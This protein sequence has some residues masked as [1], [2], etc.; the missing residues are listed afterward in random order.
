MAWTTPQTWIAGT[1]PGASD[2][3]TQIRDNLNFLL[4]GQV[5][6]FAQYTSSAGTTSTSFVDVDATNL[7][8]SGLITTGRALVIFTLVGS[9]SFVSGAGSGFYDIIRNSTTR[10]G[11][12]TTGLMAIPNNTPQRGIPVIA[13]FTGLSVGLHD[14]KLQFRIENSLGNSVAIS[15][16]APVTM[17]LLEV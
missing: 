5:A 3:N 11:N 12:A 17:I 16:I 13:L 7:K 2:F 15:N 8:I 10:A 9:V 4:S 14:F 6:S 1:V